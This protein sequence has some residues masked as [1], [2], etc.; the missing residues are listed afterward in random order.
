VALDVTE[1]DVD[2]D[3]LGRF[4]IHQV[5]GRKTPGYG[6]PAEGID[7]FNRSIVGQI[8]VVD[9]FSADDSSP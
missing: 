7:N 3:Y 4:E 2:T 9:R 5:G 1:F 6:I 8:R